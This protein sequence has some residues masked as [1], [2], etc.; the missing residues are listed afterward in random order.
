MLQTITSNESYIFLAVF[1][2]LALVALIYLLSPMSSLLDEISTRGA[3]LRTRMRELLSQRGYSDG[4][5]TH[6]L[7]GY[8]AIALDHHAAIWLLM[9]RK[10]T[11]SAWALVRPV[12]ECWIRALWINGLANEQ[13]IEQARLD[14]L[15]FPPMREMYDAIKPVYS[16]TDTREDIDKLFQYVGR[17][18][19][20]LSSYTHP[21]GR[22]IDRRLTG[23]TDTEIAQTFNLPTMVMMLL[24]RGFFLSMGHQRDADET[25]TLLTQY[26]AEFN[27]RLSNPKKGQ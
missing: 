21:G 5:K 11:G 14:K 26:F 10:L 22:Q 1:A 23:Y 24:M 18:W 19:E 2:V 3:E 13:Q 9:E 4:S 12:V 6:L 20:V 8:V 17:L 25:Y 27:E 15:R 7:V 16:Q